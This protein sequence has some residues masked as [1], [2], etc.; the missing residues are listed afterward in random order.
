MAAVA[1]VAALD[2]YASRRLRGIPALPEQAVLVNETV[3]INADPATVYDFWSQFENLPR[4]MRHLE[5]VTRIDDR[6]S[7]WVARGPAGTHV[8]WDSEIVFDQPNR[9]IA[10]RTLPGSQ[11]DHEGSVSFETAP[12]G[13]GTQLCVQMC[14]VPPLGPGAVP[15]ARL[16]GEEPKVQINDD[17]R[18]LKQLI[19]TG[20]IASTDGQPAGRRSLLGR[21]SLGR[22]VS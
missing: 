14:Y 1:G 4:F 10:W 20:E 22:R 21:L 2:V 15:I 12:A 6:T 9:R 7:H 13:R 8:E 18:R 17:L 16:L 3:I 5:R 11:I 19:E